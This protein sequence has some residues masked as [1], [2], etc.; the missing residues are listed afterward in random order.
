MLDAFNDAIVLV[1]TK[2]AMVLTN[3]THPWIPAKGIFP[4]LLKAFRASSEKKMR[5]RR[6]AMGQTVTHESRAIN[7]IPELGT[8]LIEA[9]DQGH[10]VWNE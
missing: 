1:W 2:V 6:L 9:P 10:A 5:A 4:Q 8:L 7:P 3:D